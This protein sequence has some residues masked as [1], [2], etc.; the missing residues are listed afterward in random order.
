MDFELESKKKKTLIL[1]RF[2]INSIIIELKTCEYFLIFKE[3]NYFQNNSEF[4]IIL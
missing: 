4:K 1:L 3:F 2:L